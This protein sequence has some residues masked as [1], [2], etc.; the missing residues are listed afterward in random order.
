[1]MIRYRP[2]AASF[3][4][5]CAAMLGSC[6]YAAPDITSVPANPSYA[7]DVRPLLADHCLLCHSSPPDRG[8]PRTFR[9]DVYSDTGQVAGAQSFA[10]DVVAQVQSRHMPPGAKSGDGVGP[11]GQKLLESWL[12]AG[13]PP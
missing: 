12:A 10:A 11:N 1:M 6:S 7:R 5:F 2:G 4:A 9:L 8:A 3:I 13:A